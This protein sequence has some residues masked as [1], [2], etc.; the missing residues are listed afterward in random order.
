MISILQRVT[1]ARVEVD[2]TIV[3]Q[4]GAGLLVLTA[5]QRDDTMAD[6]RWTAAKLAGLRV[7]RQGDKHF[8]LD[9]KQA[10]GGILLVSN[11][12]VA[13]DARKGRR[14]SLDGAAA[15]QQARELF[16]A[17]VEAT[18]AQGVAVETGQFAADMRITLVNDGPATFVLNSREA[19]GPT[20]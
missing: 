15:P 18:R 9:V 16:D 1:L 10:G 2:G 6:V 8:D 12:T 3:G 17:L 7:F 19:E 14:P 4:I 11:F 20:A 13:A 5:V